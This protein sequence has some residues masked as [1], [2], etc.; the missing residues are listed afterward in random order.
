ML[1]QIED[2]FILGTFLLIFLLMFM[3]YGVRAYVMFH[4]YPGYEEQK[5]GNVQIG[6]QNIYEYQTN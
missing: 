5:D 1:I 4:S 3:A 6:V 2:N